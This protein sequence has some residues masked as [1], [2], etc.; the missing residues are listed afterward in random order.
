M[1]KQIKFPKDFLW[2]G[3]VSAE[4]TEGDGITNKGETVFKRQHNERPQDFFDNVG[5]GTTI[6]FTRHY[7]ED[8]ALLK[9]YK[10]NSHRTSFSWSRLF[11]EGDYAKP[12]ADAVKMYHD[13]IDEFHK[14]NIELIVTIYHFDMPMYEL[15]KGG[16][17]SREVWQ[18]FL[19]YAK[20]VFN[21]F[22][23]KIQKWTTMN[24]PWV[25]VQSSYIHGIQWPMLKNEQ[26]AVNVAYGIVMCHALVVNY[27]N[28]YIKAKYPKNVIGAIFNSSIVYPKDPNNIDDVKAAKYLDL[29]QF[30]GLTDAM[31]TGKWNPDIIDW[32]KEM[33]LIPQNYLKEDITT[34]S[35]VNVD[36][37][38]LNYYA[39]QRAMKQNQPSRN[40]FE[41]Y[42]APYEL[43]NR[44]ENKFR[45][46]EVY[47]EAIFDT[48]KFLYNRYGEKMYM[49]T[50][51]GMG[52]ENEDI[53]RNEKSGL[54]EDNYRK[55][56]IMEHLV[57][58][59][60]VMNETK[61]NIIG[62]HI[63]TVFDCWSWNNA[64]KNR[65][66]LIEVN[67]ETQERKPKSSLEFYKEIIE[68]S[69]FEYNG[70]K[71]EDYIDFSKLKF[72]KSVVI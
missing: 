6:D 23:S 38:G 15:E 64:F 43:P 45:S 9:K 57:Q 46:W 16:F 48:F 35:R 28:E 50:E 18:D 60:R 55:A 47:P 34:L 68:N 11:P 65:Y 4:Q 17:E 13:I 67:L 63:W 56:F 58:L 71:F 21:E 44:R 8:I 24:E 5:P 32:V 7:K 2:G 41:E 59:A 49:L 39:P 30:T 51:F 25:P 53:F 20:F 1:T 29:Y 33:N 26:R 14:N 31:I 62:A 36:L 37:V 42:F 22:G 27:F 70:E 3:A 72:S 52:A 19:E 69:G 54:I 12:N 10:I 40:K 61:I 66:G